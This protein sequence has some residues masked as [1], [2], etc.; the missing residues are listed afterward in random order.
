MRE[1][2]G[3]RPDRL[4][5]GPAPTVR[6]KF[7]CAEWVLNPGQTQTQTHRRL[8]PSSEPAPTMAF[9]HDHGAWCWVRPA[10]TIAGDPRITAPVHHDNGSQ[11]RDP[12]TTEQVRQGQYRGVE[13]IKLTVEE[14]LVL[15]G[16][17]ADFIV[18]GSRSAQFLQV[19]NAVPPLMAQLLAEA[20]LG[21]LQEP[22]ADAA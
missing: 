20:N 7:R 14:A 8:R 13:P 10:T 18:C 17:P 12:K 3:D 15:Q 22:M 21:D 1:R 11:G 4:V 2:H 5:T 6:D 19:G 9:G 16:F